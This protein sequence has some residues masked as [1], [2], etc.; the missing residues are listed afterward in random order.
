[1][2][3]RADAG[4]VMGVILNMSLDSCKT[5]LGVKSLHK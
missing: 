1:M 3:S 2:S 5:I 4:I